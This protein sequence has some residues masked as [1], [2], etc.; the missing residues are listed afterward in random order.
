V[1]IV[2][3]AEGVLVIWVWKAEELGGGLPCCCCC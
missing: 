2:G 1:T 3:L